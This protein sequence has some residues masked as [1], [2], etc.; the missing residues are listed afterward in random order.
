MTESANDI[1]EVQ[2]EGAF[3][4]SGDPVDV[5]IISMV[6]TFRQEDLAP[7]KEHLRAATEALTA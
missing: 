7:I 6:E 3:L 1:D 4:L 2:Q 5:E